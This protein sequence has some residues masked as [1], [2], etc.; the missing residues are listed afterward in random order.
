MQI[1][2]HWQAGVSEL[3]FAGGSLSA[4]PNA[5]HEYHERTNSECDCLLSPVARHLAIYTNLYFR[6][7]F[8]FRVSVT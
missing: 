1:I 8:Q 7:E 2:V 5:M 3:R 6:V 4:P